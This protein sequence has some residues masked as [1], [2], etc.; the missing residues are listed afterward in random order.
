M[1]IARKRLSE[2][3][4]DIDATRNKP[5]KGTPLAKAIE[6]VDRYKSILESKKGDVS[7][8]DDFTRKAAEQAAAT[9]ERFEKDAARRLKEARGQ[10]Q[11]YEETYLNQGRPSKS[12][13]KTSTSTSAGDPAG[14]MDYLKDEPPASAAS[15]NAPAANSAPAKTSTS[16]TGDGSVVNPYVD[17]KGKPRPDAPRGGTSVASKLIDAAPGVAKDVANNVNEKLNNAELRYLK[18]KIDRKETL[19]AVDR[20]RAQRAGL[21]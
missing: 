17:T 18:D 10:V 7:K 4:K 21:L 14:V 1:E 11:M 8:V 5:P 6:T 12:G 3:E 13:S 15:A 2:T 20:V 16:R 19:S 9:V